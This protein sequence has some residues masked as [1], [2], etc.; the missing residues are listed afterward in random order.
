M[1]PTGYVLLLAIILAASVSGEEQVMNVPPLS[2][3]AHNHDI[4]SKNEDPITGSNE[5][6]FVESLK[7]DKK[8][9]QEP[10]AII[11]WKAEA[12]DPN[13]DT[14][15]CKFWLKGPG[16]GGG[17]QVVQD[18]SSSNV[19]AWRC[20]EKDVGSSDV[21]VGVRDGKH[22]DIAGMDNFEDHYNY[23]IKSR[24]ISE[25]LPP[26]IE[27]LTPNVPSPQTSGAAVN[28]ESYRIEPGT[29]S[30]L[31]IEIASDV[32]SE[33]D[34]NVY[35]CPQSNYLAVKNRIY[36]KGLDL[37]K[38]RSVKYILHESFVN[39]VRVSEAPSRDF[40]IWI[41][42]WGR[43]SISAIITTKS[44]QELEKTYELIFKSK[45]EE[46]QRKG[47]PLVMQC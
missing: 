31:N 46:A 34:R 19:W 2:Q 44:G 45:V 39:P 20:E 27:S 28:D 30:P 8:S 32:Y 35:Y 23:K 47:I 21:R 22:A 5:P 7:P 37:D 26:I 1:G 14:I 29:I 13:N 25:N 24:S 11:A 6:P 10:G 17:W 40:E 18:W 38:V 15:Y 41:M 12:G 9:P 4:N 43:F 33:N 3:P 36:L 42:T 16:T